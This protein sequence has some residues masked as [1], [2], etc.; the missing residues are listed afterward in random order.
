MG[1]PLQAPELCQHAIFNQIWGEYKCP[2]K[3]ITLYP[4][5]GHFNY[6]VACED[7]KQRPKEKSEK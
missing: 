2:K 4:N 6:C 7:F 3:G 5:L 1:L